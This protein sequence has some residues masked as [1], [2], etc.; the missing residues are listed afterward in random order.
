M[1]MLAVPV[2]AQHTDTGSAN[3]VTINLDL[4]DVDIRSAIEVLFKGTGKNY[5]IDPN[6]SGIIPSVSFKDVP[7]ETALRNLTKSSGLVYRIDNDSNIYIVSKKIDPVPNPSGGNLPPVTQPVDYVD[8][9]TESEILIEKIPLNFTSA[10]EILAMLGQ[11]S[12]RDYGGYNQMYGMS[13]FGGY[14]SGY[15]GNNSFG[16]GYGGYGG[17]FGGF[18]GFNGSSGF[19]G[20]PSSNIYGGGYNSYGGSNIY[21]GYGGYGGSSGYRR[22]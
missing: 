5:A 13:G 4:K 11:D 2:I 10:S 9:T 1:L 16:G 15:G 3:K 6:V 22:W 17:G 12:G 20:Y 21:G 14:N 19:G 8:G 18:G 7:F